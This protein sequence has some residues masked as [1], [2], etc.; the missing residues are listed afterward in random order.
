MLNLA[1]GLWRSV[2]ASD[3]FDRVR[4]RAR[5]GGERRRASLMK[6]L[7]A[8]DKNLQYRQWRLSGEMPHF[9]DIG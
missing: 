3:R 1:K 9:Y 5:H 8:H 4:E 2:L 7:V 6:A